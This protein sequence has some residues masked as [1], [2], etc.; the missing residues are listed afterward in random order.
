RKQRA[1]EIKE[2]KRNHGTDKMGSADK[3]TDCSPEGPEFKYQQ[4]YGGSKT[5]T[6][7]SDALFWRYHLIKRF[8]ECILKKAIF[9]LSPP[10]EVE[11]QVSR[12]YA[13]PGHPKEKLYS[14]T[15]E[16]DFH[17]TLEMLC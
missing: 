11:M 6:M 10:S 16:N 14:S 15:P 1:K 2:K 13:S 4:P 7:R 8:S 5:P 9:Q 17:S 3:S 12:A